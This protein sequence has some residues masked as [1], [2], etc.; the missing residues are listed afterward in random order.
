VHRPA[1][2]VAI[3]V[4]ELALSQRFRAQLWLN[5]AA[6]GQCSRTQFSAANRQLFATAHAAVT[7]L[8]AAFVLR[9]PGRTVMPTAG[10]TA[11][12]DKSL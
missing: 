5:F 6:F 2:E 1:D 12:R 4:I 10:I 11:R 9:D 8:P 7:I 3:A